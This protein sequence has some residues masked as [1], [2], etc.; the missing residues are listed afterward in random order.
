MKLIAVNG[1]PMKEVEY[2]ILLTRP[3][4]RIGRSRD[5]AGAPYDLDYKGV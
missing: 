3:S 4:S 1:S 2:A 5:E